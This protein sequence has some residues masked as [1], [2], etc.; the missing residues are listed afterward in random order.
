MKKAELKH[1]IETL[2][3][4]GVMDNLTTQISRQVVN[5]LKANG[6]AQG[7]S[8]IRSLPMT[9]GDL[10]V[11]VTFHPVLQ[12]HPL[13]A[14][15]AKLTAPFDN[16]KYAE[17]SVAVQVPQPLDSSEYNEFIPQLKNLLR[18]ELEHDRQNQRKVD[19]TGQKDGTHYVP[20]GASTKAYPNLGGHSAG[21]PGMDD[22]ELVRSYYLHP[23]E[24]EAYVMGAYKEAKTRKIPLTQVLT[25]ELTKVWQ[26]LVN[27]GM[28][29]PTIK[30]IIGDIHDAWEGYA[31]SRLPKNAKT[32]LQSPED[33]IDS[34]G[35]IAAENRTVR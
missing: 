11:L 13:R 16:D 31:L 14:G 1:L 10:Q 7:K 22:P 21:L 19:K 18:H 2:V 9:I 33:V 28:D 8:S 34:T 24:I 29:R 27:R 17:L 3:R 6:D 20:F 12:G 15:Q 30:S 26:M 5:Y 4:E 25:Q 35:E 32:G 23:Q